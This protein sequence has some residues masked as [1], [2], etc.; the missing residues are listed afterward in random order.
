MKPIIVAYAFNPSALGRQRQVDLGEFQES[1]NYIMRPISKNPAKQTNKPNLSLSAPSY[2]HTHTH[3]HT[4]TH[5]HRDT[6]RDA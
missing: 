3:T 4:H 5:R 2:I 1:K 6:Q